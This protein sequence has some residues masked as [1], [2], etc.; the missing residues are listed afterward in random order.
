LAHL[1]NQFTSYHMSEARG[2]DPPDLPLD[3]A[4]EQ[5][6]ELASLRFAIA[7]NSDFAKA[8]DQRLSTL[9][10]F[11]H[12][13]LSKLREQLSQKALKKVIHAAMDEELKDLSDRIEAL[14]ERAESEDPHANAELQ[15]V[16]ADIVVL[17]QQIE[18]RT[19]II[20]QVR[21]D[22]VVALAQFAATHERA[23]QQVTAAI[24]S[25]PAVSELRASVANL[26]KE[27]SATGAEIRQAAEE[28]AGIARGVRQDL[29]CVKYE[30]KKLKLVASQKPE[31]PAELTLL[32]DDLTE[33]QTQFAESRARGDETQNQVH[34]LAEEM[35][36][37]ASLNQ[38]MKHELD[39]K[40]VV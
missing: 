10:S 28:A 5:D 27:L 30:L 38:T 26:E 29:C 39:R 6:A 4:V 19:L 11:V 33:L 40:S 13:E 18:E 12:N 36:R 15:E 32:R 14:E 7:S 37:V 1:K 21:T 25:N 16:K 3:G 34:G 22:T 8:I 20:N 31:P 35:S 24:D 23:V 2:T 17:Q 9:N